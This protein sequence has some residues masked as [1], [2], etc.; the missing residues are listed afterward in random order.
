MDSTDEDKQKETVDEIVNYSEDDDDTTEDEEENAG[1]EQAEKGV[2]FDGTVLD[3]AAKLFS[4]VGLHPPRDTDDNEEVEPENQ[5]GVLMI[6]TVFKP[7][8]SVETP[9]DVLGILKIAK[10]AN[11]IQSPVDGFSAIQAGN[12]VI[13][14][15]T[16]NQD[17]PVAETR[18]KL[19]TAIEAKIIT[20]PNTSLNKRG[21]QQTLPYSEQHQ[22]DNEML[23]Y[24]P[25]TGA[26]E[27]EIIVIPDT[28]G[29][30]EVA[31]A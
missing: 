29:S 16:V 8:L 25:L 11:D 7:S 4:Q 10:A 24:P 20:M 9:E 28:V 3:D 22:S 18:D 15:S 27:D 2:T 13:A 12:T 5:P 14:L 26:K 17:A 6:D 21:S 23:N 31:E 30:Q 1:V 19:N